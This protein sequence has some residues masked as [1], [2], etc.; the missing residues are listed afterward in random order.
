MPPAS[1]GSS[2]IPCLLLIAFKQWIH[3]LADQKTFPLTPPSET[4]QTAYV[5]WSP[6]SHSLAYVDSNDLFVV[7]DTTLDAITDERV[8]PGHIRVTNDGGETVF[9]GIP[10]WVYEE[11]VSQSNFALWWNEKG[12]TIA[13]LKSD[14][15]EVKDYTLQFYQH[16]D[17]PGGA[18]PYPDNFVMK[19]V[20]ADYQ[21]N[22]T[23]N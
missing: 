12:D 20:P 18:Y 6:T 7:P 22:K 9:N 19:W 15:T 16:H 5:A 3:R 23:N 13:F 8:H 14:E 1:R 4:P 21:L 2:L 10:D 17:I 11:E